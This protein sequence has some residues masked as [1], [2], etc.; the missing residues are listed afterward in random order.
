MI[1]GLF[2]RSASL[3]RGGST[4]KFLFGVPDIS[5][6]FVNGGAFLAGNDPR[7]NLA[8]SRGG[9]SGH[10]YHVVM[11]NDYYI[12]RYPVTV[13]QWSKTMGVEPNGN[14]LD[15]PVLLTW[16]SM[17]K[18]ISRLN[19]ITGLKFRAPTVEEWQYAA[20]RSGYD[21]S[22]YRPTNT[23]I[24]RG[25]F[26]HV[27][28]RIRQHKPS[29]PG[30]IDMS[31][32]GGEWVIVTIPEQTLRKAPQWARWGSG[33]SGQGSR[34]AVQ[35]D[36]YGNIQVLHTLPKSFKGTEMGIRFSLRLAHP[37]L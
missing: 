28:R 18:F 5:L 12:G 4:E 33:N 25:N 14:E 27:G 13:R 30:Y 10:H 34:G 37:A 6:T 1:G 9:N 36:L 3:G 19:E 20:R 7:S 2:K 22:R 35:R 16:E 23:G 32:N 24:L 17:H 11:L 21:E 29:A 26:S 8:Q 31:G 15:L